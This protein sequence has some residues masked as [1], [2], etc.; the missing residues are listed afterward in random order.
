MREAAESNQSVV[1]AI[2]IV[3]AVAGSRDGLSISALSRAVDLPAPTVSRLVQTLVQLRLLARRP[4]SREV[5]LGMGAVRIGASHVIGRELLG[6]ARGHLEA[7]ASELGETVEISQLVDDAA[8]YLADAVEVLLRIE[9]KHV[10]RAASFNGRIPVYATSVGKI[11]LA[12]RSDKELERV[13]SGPLPPLARGT[14]TDPERL[15]AEILAV[16]RSGVA[17][18]VDEIEVGAA[19]VA[20]GIHDLRGDLVGILHV[21]GPSARLDRRRRTE[22]RGQLAERAAAIEAEFQENLRHGDDLTGTPTN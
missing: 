7:I 16:R 1:R 2:A 13:L 5:V 3:E 17:I 6:V 14:I 12:H 9:S 8:S 15:R 19:G 18:G 10:L 4:R 22:I 20:A 11:I 21:E